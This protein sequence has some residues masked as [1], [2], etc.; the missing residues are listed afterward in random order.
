MC[1]SQRD[2]NI[3]GILLF[4]QAFGANLMWYICCWRGLRVYQ[5]LRFYKDVY[6]KRTWVKV[7]NNPLTGMS[8]PAM[9]VVR[10]AAVV[11]PVRTLSLSPRSSRC[12]VGG[13]LLWPA[14]WTGGLPS[15]LRSRLAGSTAWIY[16][17]IYL[18]VHIDSAFQQTKSHA[19]H[20]KL[21][22]IIAL[23]L[24]TNWACR[25]R[26]SPQTNALPFDGFQT[27]VI[28]DKCHC[29]RRTTNYM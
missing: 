23:S 17:Y 6:G 25:V 21:H 14:V 24:A 7:R 20:C 12:T 5:G 18:F 29:T 9:S 11:W 16:I 26:H 3:A 1:C 22:H 4:Y 8:H 28:G 27:H 15:V 19:W 2:H 13:L 10:H